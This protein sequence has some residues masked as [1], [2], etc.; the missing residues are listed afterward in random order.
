MKFVSKPIHDVGKAS[1][2]WIHLRRFPHT[3]TNVYYRRI[4]SSKYVYQ[5]A[6]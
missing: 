6:K 1:Q 2:M 4:S 3:Y 5:F